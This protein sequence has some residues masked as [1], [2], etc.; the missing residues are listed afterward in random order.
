MSEFYPEVIESSKT[1]AELKL[2]LAELKYLQR[3]IRKNI[4]KNDSVRT[5]S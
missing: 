2:L 3:E 1:R 4:D 5:N